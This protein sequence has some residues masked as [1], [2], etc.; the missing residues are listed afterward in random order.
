MVGFFDI[1]GYQ[2]FLIN[3]EPEGVALEVLNM[4]TKTPGRI[5][6]YINSKIPRLNKQLIKKVKW[7]VF[8]DTILLTCFATEEKIVFKTA[9]WLFFMLTCSLLQRNML[10]F[11]LPIRGAI[12]TGA[13]IN[14]DYCSAGRPIVEAYQISRD[15]DM[16]ATVLSKGA[17]QDLIQTIEQFNSTT[18]EPT[19]LFET[20]I[21]EYLVPFKTQGPVRC[22]TLNF[23]ALD[24]PTGQ[25]PTKDLT[26]LVFEAFWKHNKD[27]S[28]EAGRKARNTE[29][30]LRFLK[31]K[32]PKAFEKEKDSKKGTS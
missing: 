19:D 3:N 32:Y 8:S 6:S 20:F 1:L 4:L 22:P 5:Q 29:E 11:G 10:D 14:K 13:F 31:Y 9:E 17:H 26:Q 12:T 18:N 16:A 21:V 30:Y 15:I 2:S 7:F 27:I 23:F 24:S 28:S 25:E